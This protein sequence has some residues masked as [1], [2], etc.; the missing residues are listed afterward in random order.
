MS[1]RIEVPIGGRIPV[2]GGNAVCVEGSSCGDCCFIDFPDC[3]VIACN[4]YNRK[5][6]TSVRFVFDEGEEGGAE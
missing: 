4:S 1:V 3:E 2:T 5:D 6:Y